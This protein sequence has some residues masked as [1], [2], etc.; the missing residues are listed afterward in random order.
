MSDKLTPG[1]FG[2][3]R[4]GTL[5]RRFRQ[6]APK[7]RLRATLIAIAAGALTFVG[8][9]AYRVTIEQRQARALQ[10]ALASVIPPGVAQEI[11]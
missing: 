9:T 2:S 1:T 3:A 6:T 8:S 5:H 7:F 11:A 10:T 4:S